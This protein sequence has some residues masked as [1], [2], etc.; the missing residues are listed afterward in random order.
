MNKLSAL[1]TSHYVSTYVFC[2]VRFFSPLRSC[3]RRN[4]LTKVRK[5]VPI[6]VSILRQLLWIF[7]TEMSDD[8]MSVCFGCYWRPSLPLLRKTMNQ[9]HKKNSN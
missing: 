8:V 1:R 2:F 3:F 9:G 6:H 7:F 5:D 4:K